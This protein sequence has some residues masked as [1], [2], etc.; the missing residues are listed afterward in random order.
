[1]F[2]ANEVVQRLVRI[3][4]R[5]AATNPAVAELLAKQ[6][7]KRDAIAADGSYNIAAEGV[8]YA[9][10]RRQASPDQRL[11]LETWWSQNRLNV[12]ILA[13]TIAW[14]IPRSWVPGPTRARG[15][16][17]AFEVSIGSIPVAFPHPDLAE[18][19][20][21][22]LLQ[23]NLQRYAIH[24]LGEAVDLF[25]N[26]V[27]EEQLLP[28]QI[29]PAAGRIWLDGRPFGYLGIGG[30]LHVAGGRRIDEHGRPL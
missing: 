8:L 11:R 27:R 20:R 6:V 5:F 14:H 18:P 2:P 7:L 30:T 21:A 22:A 28:E 17:G 13:R 9:L 16:R 26:F 19:V 10:L 4:N 25:N 29:A 3:G 24:S 1:M 12:D 15:K 23:F